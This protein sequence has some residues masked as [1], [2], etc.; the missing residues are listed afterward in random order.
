MASAG[1]RPRRGTLMSD[2][3]AGLNPAQREAAQY[4]QGPLLIL[5]GPGSGKTRVIT[6]RVAFLIRECG[7]N[8]YNV[9]AVTFTNKAAR[10][11]KERLYHLVGEASLQRLTI[12]TFHA[13]CAILLRRDGAAMGLDPHFVIYDASDQLSTIRK[14]MKALQLDEKQFPPRPILSAISAAKNEMIGV[15]D[16]AADNYRN[17]IIRRVYER[18]QALLTENKALD[19][20]DL[21]LQAVRLLRDQAEVRAR[22]QNR[23]VHVLV[24]E[25]QDTNVVQYQLIRLLSGKYNN[26]CVVGDE[27]QS[28]YKFRKADIRNILNFEKDFPKSKVIVLEQN[29]RSTQT[30]LDVARSVIAPNKE[31]KDK[32]LWTENAAGTLVTVHE[33]YDEREEGLYVLQEIERLVK[34]PKTPPNPFRPAAKRAESAPAASEPFH[35]RDFAVMYRTNAQ[36]RAVEDAFVRAS[37]PY[38][39][40]GATRFYERREIKDVLA[41]L[42]LVHNPY[43]NL[44][45]LRII[46][47]PTRGL[48]ARTLGEL[49]RAA[50]HAGVPIYV[51]LQML[52]VG[53]R[54][55]PAGAEEAPAVGL[56]LPVGGRMQEQ[57]IAFLDL[58]DGLVAARE[59]EV[60]ELLDRLLDKTGY[61]AFVL[62]GTEEGKERWQNVRELRT[63]AQQYDNEAPEASLGGFLEQVALVSDVDNYEEKVDAVT[64]LTLHS[65]K[66][67][68]F[69]VVFIV[70]MEEGLIP[71]SR[72][73]EGAVENPGEMEEERRLCYVGITRA[74]RQ[75]Y[76][77]YAFRRTLWGSSQPRD[78]SRFLA[79]IPPNLVKGRS[80]SAINQQLPW[81]A[82][83][84]TGLPGAPGL[85]RT[86]RAGAPP[87][88]V[89]EGRPGRP[90]GPAELPAQGSGS[91]ASYRTG[92]KVRH[93]KFGEGIIIEAKPGGADG[94]VTVAFQGSV[95]IKRLSLAYA[96][97]EKLP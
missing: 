90:A 14:A 3:L 49:E 71:H 45:L 38:R 48:G 41:Y 86:S 89:V 60:L 25:F 42:R 79:D 54:R 61:G 6:H 29:Y 32:R 84:S 55:A 74:M 23:Y 2:I 58:L 8:P 24:D 16:F 7:I 87:V 20:D 33:T 97:L 34:A 47:V 11:M 62:D 72:A 66:G 17:E 1:L 21:L 35:Y 15:S 27:D 92:E 9:M 64:L 50:E 36:S 12:G 28:I 65:A 70:G 39:L 59:G 46:N 31:R 78:P 37:I 43:D 44:S 22:Y 69:P 80:P 77:V 4:I 13:F 88:R 52:K 67:L 95:G 56:Q 82:K 51:A 85:G 26:V 94:E 40:L 96:P 18:Y 57:L 19:F 30:I 68:E 75:L 53:A 81:G 73:I 63:V 91:G 83:P 5:A 93:A 10:E 76:V